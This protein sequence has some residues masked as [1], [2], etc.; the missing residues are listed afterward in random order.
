MLTH[1]EVTFY[2]N[3]MNKRLARLRAVFADRGLPYDWLETVCHHG[4][5]FRDWHPCR[6]GARRRYGLEARQVWDARNNRFV[7]S[8]AARFV[9]YPGKGFRTMRDAAEVAARIN[10]ALEPF[11]LVEEVKVAALT[12][13]RSAVHDAR[14]RAIAARRAAAKATAVAA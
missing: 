12:Q 8:V 14:Q 3:E 2:Y 4:R 10:A 13:E 1:D 7:S 11:P 6:L 9:V 5:I